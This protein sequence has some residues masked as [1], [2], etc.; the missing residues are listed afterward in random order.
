MAGTTKEA[1]Y[2]IHEEIDGDGVAVSMIGFY[3]K[4]VME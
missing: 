1:I 4:T 2:F 3:T